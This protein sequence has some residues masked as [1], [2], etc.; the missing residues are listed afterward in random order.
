LDAGTSPGRAAL[1]LAR[2]Q[3]AAASK[4]CAID[5]RLDY[6]VG[7]VLAR[8]LQHDE[9]QQRFRIA[10]EEKP[11]PYLPAWKQLAAQ[12]IAAKDYAAG[13]ELLVQLASVAEQSAGSAKRRKFCMRSRSNRI[14]MPCSKTTRDCSRNN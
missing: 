10:A 4:L 13:V 8:N 12:Q 11:Y 3:A 5:P 2:A 7:L 9:A 14:F 6:A 1:D